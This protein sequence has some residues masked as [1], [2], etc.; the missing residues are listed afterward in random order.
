MK[1][2]I[3]EIK[4]IQV[5]ESLFFKYDF[6]LSHLGVLGSNL[7]SITTGVLT[8]LFKEESFTKNILLHPM[9]LKYCI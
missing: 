9:M 3:P 7:T 8:I 5:T 4:K 6:G 1:K 2:Q